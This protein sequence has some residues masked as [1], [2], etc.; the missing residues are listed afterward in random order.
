MQDGR[1]GQGSRAIWESSRTYLNP[2]PIAT[3]IWMIARMAKE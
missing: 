3:T 1:A 2:N